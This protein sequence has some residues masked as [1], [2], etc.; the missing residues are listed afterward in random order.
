[1]ALPQELRLTEHPMDGRPGAAR[2]KRNLSE[3]MRI[4]AQALEGALQEAL[5]DARHKR[6]K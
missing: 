3:D 4:A 5:N 2:P 6:R 1:M